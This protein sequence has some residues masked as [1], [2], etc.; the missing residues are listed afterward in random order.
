MT[1]IPEMLAHYILFYDQQR[2]S[3]ITH[4]LGRYSYQIFYYDQQRVSD[5]APF[6]Q[7]ITSC[8]VTNSLWAA[9]HTFLSDSLKIVLYG[10]Q[11]VS[12]I[13]HFSGRPSSSHLLL[14]STGSEW[15]Y[16]FFWSQDILLHNSQTVSGS[17]YYLQSLSLY[18]NINRKWESL[19]CSIFLFLILYRL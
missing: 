3:D 15:Y 5:V 1:Y 2:V 11:L 10:Q 9:L 8:P 19:S 4:F 7:L 6:S 18:L 16:K 13:T 12:K 17:T 14:W